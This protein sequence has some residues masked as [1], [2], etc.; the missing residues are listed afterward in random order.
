MLPNSSCPGKWQLS[1]GFVLRLKLNACCC[2]NYYGFLHTIGKGGIH[3]CTFSSSCFK[4]QNLSVAEAGPLC[5][6]FNGASLSLCIQKL[7]SLFAHQPLNPCTIRDLSP[8]CSNNI[9]SW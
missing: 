5:E 3:T 4:L 7:P 8:C 6:L 9:T 2:F 1:L